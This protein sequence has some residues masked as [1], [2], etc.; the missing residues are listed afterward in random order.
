MVFSRGQLPR[1]MIFLYNGKQLEI[2][3]D[4]NYLGVV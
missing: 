4:F 2:V 1:V 3:K